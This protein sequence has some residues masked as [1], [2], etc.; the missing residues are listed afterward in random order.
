MNYKGYLWELQLQEA[1]RPKETS[2]GS[3]FPQ[4]NDGKWSK[5]NY[6]GFDL[7]S[8]AFDGGD[9]WIVVDLSGHQLIFRSFPKLSN[10]EDFNDLA[11]RA[12][13]SAKNYRTTASMGEILSK[14]MFVALPKLKMMSYFE[15]QGEAKLGSVYERMISSKAWKDEMSKIGFV[16]TARNTTFDKF[17]V[18]FDQIAK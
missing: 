13:F 10:I 6:I 12:S 8:T 5:I 3:N 14:V 2:F 9:R 17:V 18:R 4:L 7:L 11:T 1:I 15:F 16:E